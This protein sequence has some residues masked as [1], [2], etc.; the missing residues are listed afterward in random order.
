MASV[1]AR[2]AGTYTVALVG[3]M[4]VFAATLWFA[5]RIAGLR[6]LERYVTEE[7]ATATQL[8]KQ[9][10]GRTLA[11]EVVPLTEYGKDPLLGPSLVAQARTRLD[12]L[13]NI[14]IVTDT[15]RNIVYRSVGGRLL[16]SGSLSAV[17]ATVR[18]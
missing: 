12:A 10:A 5:R 2:L 11:G 9:V 8:L 18:S 7:A 14:V 16:M 3:T 17:V 6:E 1:R 13:P 4:L 15:A